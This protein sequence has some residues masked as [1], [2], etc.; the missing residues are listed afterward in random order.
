MVE[1]QAS[2]SS[3]SARATEP[4]PLLSACLQSSGTKWRWQNALMTL[5]PCS[6]V[7]YEHAWP[8]IWSVRRNRYNS[9]Y[10]HTVESALA[11]LT[12]GQQLKHASVSA[13]LLVCTP[14]RSCLRC[15]MC[16]CDL[17][18]SSHV[19]AGSDYLLQTA[20]CKVICLEI[21]RGGQRLVLAAA[22]FNITELVHFSV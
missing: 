11:A 16:L 18:V 6:L 10:G 20:H 21:H 17:R 9:R 13:C 3:S 1:L 2:S 15:L 4:C 22:Q 7:W 14:F 12:C 5:C 19:H 8:Q